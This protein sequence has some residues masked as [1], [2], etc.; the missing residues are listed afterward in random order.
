MEEA[1]KDYFELKYLEE[2]SLLFTQFKGMD[3]YY[4]LDL[5]NTK[6]YTELFD[7]IQN[8]VIICENDFLSEDEIDN[9]ENKYN[10]NIYGKF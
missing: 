3:N 8:H 5:F 9:E 6:N 4:K 1:N 10:N 2:I 7:F